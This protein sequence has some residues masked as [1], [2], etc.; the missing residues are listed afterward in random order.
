[1]DSRFFDRRKKPCVTILTSLSMNVTSKMWY[2]KR[3]FVCQLITCVA[4]AVHNWLAGVHEPPMLAK[5]R[6]TV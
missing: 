4:P 5:E 3:K 1:M 6:P 2:C